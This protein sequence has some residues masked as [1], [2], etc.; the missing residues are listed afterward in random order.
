MWAQVV[1]LFQLDWVPAALPSVY[2]GASEAGVT[3]MDLYS[4]AIALYNAG[5]GKTVA[6]NQAIEA[7]GIT[8]DPKAQGVVAIAALAVNVICITVIITRSIKMGKNP[9]SNNV[10]E[11]TKDFDEAMA[12]AE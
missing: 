2:G 11:G 8:A 6:A 5:Q 1:P 9:Y 7:M 4:Q 12:R 3:T 10:F